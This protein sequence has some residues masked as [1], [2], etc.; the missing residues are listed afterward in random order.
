M[1]RLL[2]L[3]FALTLTCAP[4]L[5]QED[6][7]LPPPRTADSAAQRMQY[8]STEQLL[9]DTTSSNPRV[10]RPALL[11]LAVRK[12]ERAKERIVA[13]LSDPVA[14]VRSAAA[15]ALGA[16]GDPELGL[17]LVRRVRD[18]DEGVRSQAVNGLR[19]LKIDHRAAT[20]ALL[21]SLRDRS[22]GV[23]ELAAQALANC[24]SEAARVSEALLS[25]AELDPNT[26][27]AQ[28]CVKAA[29]Q[30]GRA[31]DA[32][33]RLEALYGSGDLPTRRRALAAMGAVGPP[34][35]P[36]LWLALSDRTLRTSAAVGLR[37]FELGSLLFQIDVG[38]SGSGARS[39]LRD[40]KKRAQRKDPAMRYAAI[41]LGDLALTAIRTS[42]RRDAIRLLAN[43]GA[44][45]LPAASLLGQALGSKE[46][47]LAALDAL[48]AIGPAGIKKAM[49]GLIQ[50]LETQRQDF[51][52][53]VVRL[54]G[55][56]GPGLGKEGFE[57]LE[58]AVQWGEDP[59]RAVAVGALGKATVEGA[60]SR[61]AI[62]LL[63]ESLRLDV[64]DQVRA[65]AA[66]ALGLFGR[67]ARPALPHLREVGLATK[68][69][70][71]RSATDRAASAIKR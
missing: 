22:T 36:A 7:P 35:L 9:A 45:A 33:A 64:D 46:T 68:N 12:S 14:A 70:R 25:R 53:R 39:A 67:S 55:E 2:P 69:L 47:A 58:A 8:A 20:E 28:V 40:L 26:R 62:E 34:A 27:V 42:V 37:A 5:A 44:D 13:C 60:Q 51:Q 16:L 3:T 1:R 57:A 50:A 4:L 63:I 54:I 56:A 11:A 65:E 21:A 17:E 66:K 19:K 15:E 41:P 29:C 18:V 32:L 61:R 43:L 6:G 24:K 48:G 23:R 30:L 71:L 52:V 59:V 49:P 10:R 31:D 38:S